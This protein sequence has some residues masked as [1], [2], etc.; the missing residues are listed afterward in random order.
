MQSHPLHKP[1]HASL[2]CLRALP[3]DEV[4]HEHAVSAA[5][6]A[7][8]MVQARVPERRAARVRFHEHHLHVIANYYDQEILYVNKV[9]FLLSI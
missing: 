8:N 4:R 9:P 1:E 3:K 6:G 7:G 2:L 5:A